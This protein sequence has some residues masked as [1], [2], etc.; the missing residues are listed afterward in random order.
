MNNSKHKYELIYTYNICNSNNKHTKQ[1][2]LNSS[3]NKHN[4]K[5]TYEMLYT[6]NICNSNNKHTKLC[7]LNSSNNKHSILYYCK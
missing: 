4:S 3:N 7:V 5:H 2:V 1:Y 6:Y